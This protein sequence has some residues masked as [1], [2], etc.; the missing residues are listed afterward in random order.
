MQKRRTFLLF[1]STCRHNNDKHMI[2]V[3]EASQFG[4]FWAPIT[5]QL[6]LGNN[7]GLG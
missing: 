5:G 4:Q 2:K 3:V 1:S 7:D 6:L